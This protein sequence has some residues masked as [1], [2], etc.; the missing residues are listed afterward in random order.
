MARLSTCKGCEAK[1][2]KEE[3][4]IY[5]NKSYCKQC[6]DKIILEKE[7]YNNL[8]KTICE[9]FNIQFPEGLM[10]KQIKDYKEQFGY[11]YNGMSYTL[12]YC[13]EI[14]SKNF[15]KKYG[16]ALIKY[17]YNNAKNYFNSQQDIKNSIQDIKENSINRVIINLD[18][19]YQKD[20]NKMLFNLD[21]LTGGGN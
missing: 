6:Y 14:L 5:S 16:V 19:L 1:L 7:S 13:K 10:Y 18:K 8:I 4:F 2:T 9:Y 21:D 3:K 15:D 12:W 11:T 20:K 17:E